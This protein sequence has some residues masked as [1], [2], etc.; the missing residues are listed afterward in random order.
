[1]LKSNVSDRKLQIY[2]GYCKPTNSTFHSQA[3]I[4]LNSRSR[5]QTSPPSLH[6]YIYITV[7]VTTSILYSQWMVLFELSYYSCVY[8]IMKLSVTNYAGKL[9]HKPQSVLFLHSISVLCFIRKRLRSS[10]W[11]KFR[12]HGCVLGTHTNFLGTE[13]VSQNLVLSSSAFHL[14]IERTPLTNSHQALCRHVHDWLWA[15]V[16]KSIEPRQVP[17]TGGCVTF[18]IR[19]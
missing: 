15:L 4:L 12:H 3:Y 19:D 9:T 17:S 8:F 14:P 11:N 2:T 1:M 5:D 7:Q 18:W 6:I 10:S 16:V 13:S